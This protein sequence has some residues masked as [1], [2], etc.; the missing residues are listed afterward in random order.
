MTIKLGSSR[1]PR[2]HLIIPDAH[3]HPGDNTRRFEWLSNLILDRKPEVIVQIGDW[4]DMGSLCS[5]DAGKKSFVFQNLKDDIETGHAVEELVYSPIIQE[6][7]RLK[8]NKRKAYNPT[9]IS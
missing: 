9:E 2:S 8:R 6:G 5:H 1:I 4:W 7:E 3:T